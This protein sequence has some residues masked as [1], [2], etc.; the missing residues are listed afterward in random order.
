MLQICSKK[1]MFILKGIS[2]DPVLSDC[3]LCFIPGVIYIAT[4]SV[5]QSVSEDAG[6]VTITLERTEVGTSEWVDCDTVPGK[7]SCLYML[8]TPPLGAQSIKLQVMAPI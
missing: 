2:H 1:Y 7:L 4:A 3:Q 8:I 6:S 5:S